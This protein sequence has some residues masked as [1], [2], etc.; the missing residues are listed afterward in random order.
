MLRLEPLPKY[1]LLLLLF[2]S[3]LI[4]VAPTAVSQKLVDGL[5]GAVT[6]IQVEQRCSAGTGGQVIEEVVAGFV[7]IGN[8]E[9]AEI[10]VGVVVV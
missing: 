1:H 6:C 5:E 9:V 2:P 10:V 4:A 7:F 8:V 3:T